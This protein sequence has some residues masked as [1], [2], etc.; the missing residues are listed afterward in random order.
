[1]GIFRLQRF[2]ALTI[3]ELH[4][5][6]KNKRLVVQLIIMPTVALTLFGLSLNPEVKGLRTGVVDFSRTPQSRRL[7]DHITAIQAFRVTGWYGSAGE[8]ERALRRLELDLVVVIPGDFA[9]SIERRRPA[10]IQVWI[11]AVNAN[12]ANIAQGYLAQAVSGYSRSVMLA[13]QQRPRQP[14][15]STTA[16]L[17]NPGSRHAWFYVTGVMSVLIFINA[18]LVSSALAVREKELGTIEQ[19]LMSPAQTLEML[20]AKTA[21]VLMVA[22]VVLLVAMAVAALVFDVPMRGSWGLLLLSASL[23]AVC[24]IG[25]GITIATFVSTQQQAQLL[26]F[27]LMPPL[28]LV[29]GAFTPVETMPPALQWVSAVD[30]IRY[31]ALLLR[32][33]VLKGAGLDVLWPQLAALFAFSQVLYGLSAWRFRNQLR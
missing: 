5:L 13:W 9:R 23:A 18:S 7:V 3:K 30:P 1:M 19:L 26:T 28:V 27:L 4:Q 22:I 20:L 17:Y 2:L 12:F 11:D 31:M 6:R 10:S 24:G 33:V 8:A 32:G 25:I 21:P 29:S 16:V 14:V 15:S